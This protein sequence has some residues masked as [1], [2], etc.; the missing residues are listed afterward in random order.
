MFLLI[1][2]IVLARPHQKG[3]TLTM[4]I[5]Q[6]EQRGGSAIIPVIILAIIGFGAY[7]GIQYLPQYIEASTVD[8]ILGNI[9]KANAKTPLNGVNGI[10]NVIDKQLNI[11]QMND[12]KD[13]FKVKQ[14]GEMYTVKVSYERELNLIYKKKAVKY[15]KSITL[16]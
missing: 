8:T 14:D 13:N 15:E 4:N 11:N 6:K 2:L 3:H 5:S 12:L 7:L 9:E 10:Q 16:K 1:L